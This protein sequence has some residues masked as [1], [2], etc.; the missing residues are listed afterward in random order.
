[1]SYDTI[2]RY[3]KRVYSYLNQKCRSNKNTKP[4]QQSKRIFYNIIRRSVKHIH[5]RHNA[6]KYSHRNERSAIKEEIDVKTAEWTAV[7]GVYTKR[8]FLATVVLAII[9]AGTL[10]AIKGQLDVMEADQRPW[11]TGTLSFSG[12]LYLDNSG[13]HL[14]IKITAK[15]IGKSPAFDVVAVPRFYSEPQDFLEIRAE[16]YNTASHAPAHWA[17]NT[18]FPSETHEWERDI[19]IQADVLEKTTKFLNTHLPISPIIVIGISY[20]FYGSPRRHGTALIWRVSSKNRSQN[21]SSPPE[22]L[23]LQPDFQVG[24]FAD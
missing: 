4:R 6:K 2:K 8:L 11:I 14:K 21:G 18:I 3:L 9:S 22:D 13:I 10:W 7:V 23:I 12:P 24:T 16:A 20:K 1:M 19:T 5:V 15:N 17:N